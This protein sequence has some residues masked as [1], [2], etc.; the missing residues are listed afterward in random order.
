MLLLKLLFVLARFILIGLDCI[1]TDAQAGTCE[2]FKG[3]VEEGSSNAVLSSTDCSLSSGIWVV[4]MI[5]W[6]GRVLDGQGY[7]LKC[8]NWC[9]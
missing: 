8:R 9:E 5:M 6:E 1:E 7:K 3:C 4:C 2:G